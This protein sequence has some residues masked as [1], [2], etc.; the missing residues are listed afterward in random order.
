[1]LF[2]DPDSNDPKRDARTLENAASEALRCACVFDVAT[3]IVEALADVHDGTMWVYRGVFVNES[4]LRHKKP[5]RGDTS[6]QGKHLARF[7]R[8]VGMSRTR[9]ILLVAGGI[10]FDTADAGAHG[11]SAVLRKPF[12]KTGFCN[13]LRGMYLGSEP[14]SDDSE[15]AT[16]AEAALPPAPRPVQASF[17]G[18]PH[19]PTKRLRGPEGAPLTAAAAAA[20]AALAGSAAMH[21]GRAPALTPSSSYPACLGFTPFTPFTHPMIGTYSLGPGFL[22]PGQLQAG[23]QRKYTKIAPREKDG[24]VDLLAPSAEGN[25]RVGRVTAETSYFA[26]AADRAAEQVVLPRSA[27]VGSVALGKDEVSGETNAGPRGGDGDDYA[28]GAQELPL[29]SASSVDGVLS[30]EP[31]SARGS[32]EAAAAVLV[33][34]AR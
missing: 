3:D 4:L 1:M 34:K 12:T 26:I 5:I 6:I 13:I 27:G 7:L 20:A 16:D 9:M 22:R 29:L 31:T 21:V 2:V 23:P 15:P 14:P 24:A 28:S 11:L 30:G 18:Q 25:S 32:T 8:Q 10:D 19:C 17:R 33:P